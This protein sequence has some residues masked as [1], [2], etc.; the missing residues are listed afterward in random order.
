MVGEGSKYRVAIYGGPNTTLTHRHLRLKGH[1]HNRPEQRGAT[2]WAEGNQTRKPSGFNLHLPI[3]RRPHQGMQGDS[4]APSPFPLLPPHARR[5]RAKTYPL[6]PP[7]NRAGQK[8][9]EALHRGRG[10]RWPARAAAPRQVARPRNGAGSKMP[11]WEGR[12]KQTQRSLK[13]GLP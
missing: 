2:Q 3:G 13:A 9:A 11:L 5:P 1:K 6:A 12:Q 7:A 8:R 4:P 10:P